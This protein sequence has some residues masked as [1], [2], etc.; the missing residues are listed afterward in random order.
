MQ[1]V[2]ASDLGM[3]YLLGPNMEINLDG[4]FAEKCWFPSGRC[5]PRLGAKVVASDL[6][7]HYSLRPNMKIKL[8]SCSA[9]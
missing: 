6:G 5:R 1:Q 7:K 2:A 4:Y 9:E 8:D 3:H